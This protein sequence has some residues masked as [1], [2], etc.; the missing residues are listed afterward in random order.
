MS[1]QS[2][3]DILWFV[4]FIDVF[5]GRSFF[6]KR[7]IDKQVHLDACLSGIGGIFD[8][9]VYQAKFPAQFR[10]YNI[11]AL[12]MANILIALKVWAKEWSHFKVEIH[13]DNLAVVSVLQSGKTRD[14]ILAT[15]S[16]Y[17][18]SQK[19]MSLLTCYRGG[20]GQKKMKKNYTH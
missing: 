14:S 11:A 9:K 3:R 7:T 19:L 8:N 2:L 17:L 20:K 4:K 15:F 16:K 10:E 1:N 18:I 6:D 5:N 13:S 12:E